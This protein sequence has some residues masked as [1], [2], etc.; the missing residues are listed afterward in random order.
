MTRERVV[1]LAA[2]LTVWLAPPATAQDSS[3]RV[4]R[5]R[6]AYEDLQMFSQVLNQIRVNHPDSVDTHDLLMAA[7]SGMVHAADPHSYVISAVRASPEKEK[8]LADKKVETVPIDWDF[9]RG[10]P[11]VAFVY[12]GTVAAKLDIQPGDLLVQV[13]GKPVIA[14]NETEL[15]ITL[16]GVKG[17]EVELTFERQRSDGTYA[18]L[19]RTVKRERSDA[20]ASAVPAVMQ[21]GAGTGYVRI[22]TFSNDKVAEDLHKALET[23]DGQGIQRLI[24][25]LR[26]NGGGIV[27]EASRIAAE[28]L[29]RGSIV[30]TSKGRKQE[31]IDTGRVERALWG[32][33]RT[34]PIAVMVNSGTASASELVAGALQDHDRAVI[35][36]RPSFGK[37]LMM[38]NFPMADGSTIVL[39]IG[40]VQT[41]CGRTVQRPYR[42]VTRFEYFRLARADRDTAGRPFCKTDGGRIVYGGGGIFPDVMLPERVGAP[43]WM[44]RL[45]EDDLVARWARGYA[46]A[47]S[48]KLTMEGLEAAKALPAGALA[49][50]KEF[51]TKAGHTLPADADERLGRSV[52]A[53]LASAVAGDKGFF[54]MRALLDPEVESAVQ[55]LARSA[56]ILA[57]KK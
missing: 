15:D 42:S 24:L 19:V 21:L 5:K 26:D 3:A 41:P 9:S 38:Q 53:T 12:P 1:V 7:I 46:D 34:Y 55:A 16:T 30:Y 47:A 8:E 6:T 14:D 20:T 49:A 57:T 11:T 32:R 28:F 48:P 17:S 44:S 25:D 45:Y 31:A 18:R 22:T 33:P 56:E 37:A 54:R 2:T 35:V 27:K 51:A 13:A 36:G 39:V 10:A 43:V 23:L 4:V 29:P 52:L 40:S 50:F